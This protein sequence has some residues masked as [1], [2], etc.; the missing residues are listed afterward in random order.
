MNYFRFNRSNKHVFGLIILFVAVLLLSILW[1]LPASWVLSKPA[2]KNAIE[3]KVNASQKLKITASRGTI[4]Q[5]EADLAIENRSEKNGVSQDA[6]SVGKVSW[7]LHPMS[8]LLTKLSADIHWQL[9]QSALVG[10]VSMGVFSSAEKRKIHLSNA[11]GRIDL[12]DLMPKLKFNK[13]TESPFTQNIQGQISFNYLD[14]EYIVQTRWFNALKSEIQVDGLLVMN[15]VFPRLDI[16][17]D[18]EDES[19]Q[20]RLSGQQTNWNLH[21]TA[22]LNRSYSYL[23]NL[24]LKVDS[25]KNLPDWAFAMQ[26]KSALNYVTELQ[27]NL[28]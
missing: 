27:A 26:K 15:N 25:E 22:S 18:I 11:K 6:F 28:F 9:G 13:I 14:A 17:T 3:Q 20:A 1:Q 21:G 4:W 24:N 8:L 2:I 10:N 7:K 16:Q 23:L 19:I 5:G 12:K